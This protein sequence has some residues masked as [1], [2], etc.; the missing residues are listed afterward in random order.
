[1]TSNWNVKFYPP[2][3][4]ADLLSY[5][6]HQNRFSSLRSLSPI[7]LKEKKS[8]NLIE[9][10]SLLEK[11]INRKSSPMSIIEDSPQKESTPKIQTTESVK[12][13]DLLPYIYKR[14]RRRSKKP[15]LFVLNKCTSPVTFLSNPVNFPRPKPIPSNRQ[16]SKP[17]LPTAKQSSRSFSLSP[18]TED[19]IYDIR[20]KSV[21]PEIRKDISRKELSPNLIR[22]L[23]LSHCRNP[24][25]SSF[26]SSSNETY[27][28]VK[29]ELTPQI[30][31]KWF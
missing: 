18:A 9:L 19:T 6:K 28:Y 17:K 27:D 24:S 7:L 20:R 10:K 12:K 13:I 31:E 3:P 22:K 8:E 23:D 2:R 5:H 1:M 16:I 14:K 4:L 21:L 29:N 30:M 26:L 25:K 15:L 11:A